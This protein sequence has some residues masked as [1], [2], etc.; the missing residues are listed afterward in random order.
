MQLTNLQVLNVTQ[1]LSVLSQNKL[2][3]KLS[4]KVATAIRSLE[5]FAKSVDEPMKELRMKY[6]I[7][8]QAGNYI[9]ALDKE[10]KPLPN[11]IQIPS[12]KVEILNKE[13]DELL[14]QTVMVENVTLHIS[15]FPET[16]QLEPSVLNALSPII[17]EN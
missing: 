17:D 15:D 9:E 7:K 5:P 3:I 12:D 8:D 6:A 13:M 2:P 11:T 4:W 16:L 1:A 10:G 14:T